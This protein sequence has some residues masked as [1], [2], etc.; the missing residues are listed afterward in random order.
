[1]HPYNVRV[2]TPVDAG[3]LRSIEVTVSSADMERDVVRAYVRIEPLW[4]VR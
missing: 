3:I 4:R 2:A 1:M